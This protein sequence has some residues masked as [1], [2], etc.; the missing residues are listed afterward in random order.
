MRID[1]INGLPESTI[2]HWHGLHVPEAM[3]GQRSYKLAWNDRSALTVIA[4]DV[5]L[6]AAPLQRDCVMLA[7]AERVDLWV[8]FGRW[9]SGSELTLQSL[10]LAGDMAMGMMTWGVNGRSFE[11]ERAS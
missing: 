4:T 11:M 2:I 3:D 8:D 1:L 7:P 5:G 10:A 6:L 9:P